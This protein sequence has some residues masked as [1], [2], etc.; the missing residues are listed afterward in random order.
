MALIDGVEPVAGIPFAAIDD[1]L[2][3]RV[4]AFP[5]SDYCDPISTNGT[6]SDAL[7]EEH[8]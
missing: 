4:V 8:G 6:A 1:V 3:P 7:A 2:G 5:F